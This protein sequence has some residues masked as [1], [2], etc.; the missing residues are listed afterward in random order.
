MSEVVV[1]SDTGCGPL[2]KGKQYHFK[3][4]RIHRKGS[5]QTSYHSHPQYSSVSPL[6]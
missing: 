3:Q 5:L 1:W 2:K 6:I 4:F